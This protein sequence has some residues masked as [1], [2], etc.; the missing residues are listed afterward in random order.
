MYRRIIETS[1][2]ASK[3]KDKLKTSL[4]SNSDLKDVELSSSSFQKKVEGYKKRVANENDTDKGNVTDTILK[5]IKDNKFII[6]HDDFGLELNIIVSKNMRRLLNEHPIT[7]PHASNTTKQVEK[8]CNWLKE[9]HKIYLST[10]S[11]R[12][13]LSV[14]SSREEPKEEKDKRKPSVIENTYIP[15]WILLLFTEF[16]DVPI[17]ELYS[18]PDDIDKKP[19]SVLKAL[20]DFEFK[21]DQE[22]EKIAYHADHIN[23]DI[24]SP[25]LSRSPFYCYWIPPS[26]TQY[27][28]ELASG[29]LKFEKSND[30]LCLV[31]LEIQKGSTRSTHSSQK[32]EKYKGIATSLYPINKDGNCWVFLRSVDSIFPSFLVFS[33]RLTDNDI[34]NEHKG[35]THTFFKMA[36]QIAV[37]SNKKRST[38]SRLFFSEKPLP[39]ATELCED[40]IKMT[41]NYYK[42]L[43]AFLKLG[44]KDIR[45]KARDYNYIK[46][47]FKKE[48]EDNKKVKNVLSTFFNYY[49]K[50]FEESDDDSIVVIRSADIE[51]IRDMPS[52][53]LARF[54][55]KDIAPEYNKV[56]FETEKA[57]QSITESW[58]NKA[59][60]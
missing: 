33:F 18:D 14:S 49:D 28:L 47:D 53:F 41:N 56:T 20:L 59:D 4:K 30:G 23:F 51:N 22:D 7:A 52:S 16:M 45:I 48:H 11:M 32:R 15:H 42:D 25:L 50:L 35:N 29:E 60:E 27:Y 46:S 12:K 26:A 57:L 9:K 21:K 39:E 6:D 44:G 17:N 58:F 43:R 13:Y 1:K 19:E 36:T 55:E 10:V 3:F 31:E 5:S 37:T 8:F 38:I 40:G 24:F 2:V 54:R 34:M